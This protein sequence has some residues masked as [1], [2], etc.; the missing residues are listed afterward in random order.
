[1]KK[2][3]LAIVGPTATGKTNL[4][5]RLSHSFP[6]ILVSADSRQVYRSMNIVTGK[7]HPANINI[8]GVDLIDPSQPSSVSLWH[9]AV[10]PAI[11]SA[12]NDGKMVIVVGGTALYVKALI[13]NI[14]TLKVPINS[15][16]RKSLEIL[17]VSDLQAKLKLID[18]DK[19]VQMNN[20]DAHN[21]RRLIRAIE[22]AL[23]PHKPSSPASPPS[24][25]LI[26]L[27][28]SD[29][30][31]YNNIVRERVLKRLQ[32]GALEETKQQLVVANAQSFT[33][34]GYSSLVAHLA[35]EL[36]YQQMIESWVSNE[37][38]YAKRQMT[39]FRKLPGI[40]WFP[41]ETLDLAK[42]A[43]YVKAWYDKAN[44]IGE[45]L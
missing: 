40:T 16:L 6:S 31:I 14:E 28:Y 30:D 37:L 35:G 39:F 4:A 32:L 5:I 20:S 7:D 11:N 27:N 34:L 42:V 17:S 1:M 23:S 33:A 21:P 26:G 18:Q 2:L 29:T 41:V 10:M 12:W 25:L 8:L 9:D 3:I 13:S 24:S 45:E 22:V 36:S 38:G 15:S 44:S 43:S 19:L